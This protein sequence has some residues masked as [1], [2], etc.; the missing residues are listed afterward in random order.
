[1]STQIWNQYWI[2][3]NDS[4]TKYFVSES[5]R[6]QI[7]RTRSLEVTNESIVIPDPKAFRSMSRSSLILSAIA[8][9]AKEV[10][11]SIQNEDLFSIGVYCAVEN[12]PIDA[13]ST[14][15][16]LE[17]P[18]E[19]FAEAYR[20]LRN[21][22]FYLK[23]LPNLVPAQLGISL[24]LLGRMN[25]YTHSRTGSIQ[26]LEQAEWDLKTKKVSYALVCTAFAF[27]DFLVVKRL[28]KTDARDLSEGAAAMI[29]KGDGEFIN[30]WSD[31]ASDSQQTF[32]IADPLVNLMK[33]SLHGKYT[34][35]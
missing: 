24:N 18:V 12:G 32:G 33:G 26:A 31:I 35:A 17:Q 15:K 14:V 5:Y 3:S 25:V 6:D 30:R 13:A 4:P 22:K 9:S 20:K 27:D 8:M 29:L 1:M 19:K 34:V 21:P 10:L 28:R 11:L 23:Q 2:P 7:E 16:I